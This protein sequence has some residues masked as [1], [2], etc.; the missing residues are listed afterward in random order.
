LLR[1]IAI[2]VA[3]MSLSRPTMPKGEA[4]RYA[5]ALNKAATEASFDPLIAVAIVHFESHWTPNLISDDGEDYGLGQVRGRYLSACRDD[6]DPLHEP[7]EACKEA[8]ATL[9]D[10]VTNIRRMGGIIAANQQ[11]CRD[12]VGAAFPAQWLAGYQGLNDLEHSRWCQPGEK[13]WRVLGYYEELLSKFSPKTKKPE[14]MPLAKKATHGR[15]TRVAART[16]AKAP[17]APAKGPAGK[18]PAPAA[19]ASVKPA[20]PA[21]KH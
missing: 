2:L 13:T 6:A 18:A 3:A 11:F 16:P 9:L 1:P 12:K 17:P 19:K 15:P 4:V 8:K 21:P 7:S 5:E 10:G 20:A 14:F